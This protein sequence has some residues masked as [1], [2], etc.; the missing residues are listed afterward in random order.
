[1][2][3]LLSTH[4]LIWVPGDMPSQEPQIIIAV[5][6]TI[7]PAM[8]EQFLHWLSF[9]VSGSR[10]PWPLEANTVLPEYLKL[11]VCCRGGVE[12]GDRTTM[13]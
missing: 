5:L 12:R 7:S 4:V 10:H 9:L 3:S 2:V 13:T 8:S 6:P 1:M 11:Y